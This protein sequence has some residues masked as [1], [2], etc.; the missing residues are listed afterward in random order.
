[1]ALDVAGFS[2]EVEMM[3]GIL[4]PGY[5]WQV[6]NFDGEVLA[7]DNDGTLNEAGMPVSEDEP[8]R[9]FSMTKAIVS[10]ACAKMVELGLLTYDDTPSMHIPSI[11]GKP[12][13]VKRSENDQREVREPTIGELLQH[14][15]GVVYPQFYAQYEYMNSKFEEA[16]GVLYETL[17]WTE[18]VLTLGLAFEPGTNCQYGYGIDVV[19]EVLE[20][21]E[22]TDLEDVVNKYIAEPLGMEST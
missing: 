21:I 9:I 8:V 7:E 22:G 10:A 13:Y 16:Y 12:W 20:K 6:R 18:F 3:N 4:Y 1:M 15:S 19:G 2:A 14:T 11:V 5:L 17:S